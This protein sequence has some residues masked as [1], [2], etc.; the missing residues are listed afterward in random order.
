MTNST[1]RLVDLSISPS[2]ALLAGSS[3]AILE[4]GLSIVLELALSGSVVYLLVAVS[5][6]AD[7]ELNSGLF[8]GREPPLAR[9]P[10]P[11]TSP[12]AALLL[13]PTVAWLCSI[14]CS[15]SGRLL[16]L[17]KNLLMNSRCTSSSS[18]PERTFP[19]LSTPYLLR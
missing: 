14:S 19:K 10:S 18:L 2:E 1:L 9:G 15:A 16:S 17:S 7:R 6:R 3:G 5:L 4:S 11:H 8:I 13:F 12:C